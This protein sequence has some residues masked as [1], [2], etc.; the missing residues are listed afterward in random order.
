MPEKGK[1]RRFFP[2]SNS[3]HG[4]FSYYDQIMGPEAVRIFIIKGGPGVGKSTFMRKIAERMLACGYDVEYHYC[5][6][7][8]ESIDAIAFHTLG[9]ALMDG[10]APHLIDPKYPG[11]V[12][13]I[14]S[15]GDF[16]DDLKISSQKTPIIKITREIKRT[17]QNAYMLLHAA[18][19]YLKALESYYNLEDYGDKKAGEQLLLR[20]P[21]EILQEKSGERGAGKI[22]KLFASAL[23]P[24][25]MVNHLG[26]L[27]NNLAHTYILQGENGA[28]KKKIT[29][30]IAEEA[31][32][33]GFFVEA[34]CCALDPYEID[35]LLIPELK[36][37][38]INS[39]EPHLFVPLGKSTFIATDK[40]NDQLPKE[41]LA[42]RES[43]RQRYQEALQGALGFLRKAK[44]LHDELEN[45]YIPYMCFDG[46]DNLCEQTLG[47]IWAY[48]R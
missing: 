41:L 17:F 1:I 2:G 34:F 8:Q 4:F 45:Y 19:L 39:Q 33:R 46:I 23:T 24:Q 29:K 47:R 48:A 26:T 6:S 18:D 15:L 9:I 10:T 37:G 40:T 31:V 16:W 3:A 44:V 20:L 21:E 35:H 30:R 13:E 36:M 11:A 5:S 7:D 32:L 14:I 12:D 43:F 22:R 28:L 25:G 27:T 42:E 38:I